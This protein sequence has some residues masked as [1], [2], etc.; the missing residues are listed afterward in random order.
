M[1]TKKGTNVRV[2]LERIRT[3]EMA[4]LTHFR[5]IAFTPPLKLF[6]KKKQASLP[7]R[8]PSTSDVAFHS[9]SFVNNNNKKVSPSVWPQKR[10]HSNRTKHAYFENRTTNQTTP[11]NTQHTQKQPEA[12][13]RPLFLKC[14]EDIRLSSSS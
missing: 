4:V 12:N 7:T 6:K 14:K 2:N 10:L 9:N 3:W 11:R 5:H 8:A 13:T 1:G